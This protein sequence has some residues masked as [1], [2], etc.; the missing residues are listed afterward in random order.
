[1][2]M[3]SNAFA[4]VP[5][6]S[7]LTDLP[8]SIDDLVPLGLKEGKSE[9]H[10]Y[11]KYFISKRGN[12]NQDANPFSE[13]VWT[14]D[15][16]NNMNDLMFRMRVQSPNTNF[17]IALTTTSGSILADAA[18]IV[19][20]GASISSIISKDKLDSGDSK[21]H[22][23]FHFYDFLKTPEEIIVHEDVHDC[24]LPHIVLEMSIMKKETFKARK[25]GYLKAMPSS[26]PIT[27][28]EI[29]DYDIGYSNGAEKSS[30][31]TSANNLY[32]LS[33]TESTSQGK[34]Q[35][36]K[37]YHISI[38]SEEERKKTKDTPELLYYLQLQLVSDFMTSGSMH[39]VVVHEKDDND[40]LV[41]KDVLFAYDS[42]N[43]AEEMV[44]VVS[45]RTAKNE[46]SL[47][48]ALTEGNYGIYFVDYQNE[49]MR[50]FI[51]DTVQRIPF[52]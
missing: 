24:H 37:E 46:E 18:S 47:N 3:I 15:L 31:K 4:F 13:T 12:G 6:C 7:E 39:V 17:K 29:N 2:L 20:Y 52:R 27:F 8:T 10:V 41:S 36:L 11:R 22:I 25:E 40:P 33:K 30:K 44:C 19:G 48:I 28:P 45:Q 51:A 9:I 21:A 35:I 50:N 23:K 34:F 49:Q 14:L 43:C 26:A 1:M 5:P 32:S 42:L 38:S 16:D